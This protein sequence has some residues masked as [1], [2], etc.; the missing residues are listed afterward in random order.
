MAENDLI[1][2]SA[3][4]QLEYVISFTHAVSR[5]AAKALLDENERLAEAAGRVDET[6]A[7]AEAL[8]DTCR[9]RLDLCGKRVPSLSPLF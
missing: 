9:E 8:V 7:E 2:E 4:F 3:W 6:R 5:E 1:I